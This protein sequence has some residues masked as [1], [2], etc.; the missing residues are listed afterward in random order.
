[1]ISPRD[2]CLCSNDDGVGVGDDGDSGG[3]AG[4]DTAGI[5]TNLILPNVTGIPSRGFQWIGHRLCHYLSVCLSYCL[6]VC[7]S[8]SFPP[9]FSPGKPTRILCKPD[10]ISSNAD[11]V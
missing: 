4:I 1:M 10:T 2:C 6:L 7:L 9:S 11:Q 8:L 3:G 5:V